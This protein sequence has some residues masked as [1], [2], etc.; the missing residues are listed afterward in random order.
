MINQTA[1]HILLKFLLLNPKQ[2]TSIEN[3]IHIHDFNDPKVKYI[4]N[5]LLDFHKQKKI[6]DLKKIDLFL[7]IIP[8]F[9][10]KNVQNYLTLILQKSPL[11]HLSEIN[12]YIQKIKK[13]SSEKEI[14]QISQTTSLFATPKDLMEDILK[15]TIFNPS[16][17]GLLGFDTGFNQLNHDTLG[18]QK[19]ELII[20]GARPGVGKT[21]LMMNL[22]INIIIKNSNTKIVIFSLEMS[23][24]Q[25]ILKSLS[26]ISNVDMRRLRLGAVSEKEKETIIYSSH[27]L[28]Q[29]RLFFDDESSLVSEIEVK[30]NDFKQTHGLDM[31]FIDYLQL[32]QDKPVD[33]IS[34]KLKQLAKKLNIV[35]FCLAQLNRESAKSSTPR[36]PKLTDLKDTGNIEQDADLVMLLYCETNTIINKLP[37]LKYEMII[38]KNRNGISNKT[39]QLHFNNQ[40][41]TFTEK[42]EK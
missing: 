6:W 8:E 7:T 30:C 26:S 40:T 12:N 1:E 34:K 25:L 36:R 2:F 21:T 38:A 41:Q 18:F 31:V 14:E 37:Q 5:L 19:K 32:L 11:C 23:N 3:K 27:T 16:K 10:R 42:I 33:K 22:A 17:N 29:L 35:I 4:Y 9:K 24:T 20:L 15:K 13:D 28:G 39:Y